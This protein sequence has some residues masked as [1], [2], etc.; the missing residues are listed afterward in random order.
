MIRAAYP[1]WPASLRGHFKVVVE[2]VIG[3]DGH[4][5][6]TRGVS[7]PPEAYRACEDAAKQYAF[8]PFLVLDKPVE[9]QR[10]IS[11]LH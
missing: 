9:V 6:S 7:G 1:Q 4:V 5:I 11:F 10:T 2:I 8:E 3:K